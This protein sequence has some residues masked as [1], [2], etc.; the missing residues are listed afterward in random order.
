[1]KIIVRGIRDENIKI[2]A[3]AIIHLYCECESVYVKADKLSN[4]NLWG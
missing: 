1:M 4:G 3:K 2:E